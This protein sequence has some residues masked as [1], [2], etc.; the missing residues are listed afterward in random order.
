M[1]SGQDTIVGGNQMETHYSLRL[2]VGEALFKQTRG[3]A[4]P[5]V[6]RCHGEV[7]DLE[8]AAIMEQY[9]SAQDEA[10]HFS[11]YNALKSVILLAFKQLTNMNGSVF[12]RPVVVPRLA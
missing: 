5:L 9:G 11:V 12:H 2:E 3:D 10:C 6:L 1:E 4:L 7:V 8:G